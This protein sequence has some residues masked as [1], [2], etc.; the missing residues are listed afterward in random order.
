MSEQHLAGGTDAAARKYVAE[1]HK[2]LEPGR[3][4]NVLGHLALAL[5]CRLRRA[6]AATNHVDYVDADGGVHPAISAD[7]FIVLRA[8]N[9]S[10]LVQLRQAAAEAGVAC[11]DF[12][13]TMGEGG[14]AEQLRRTAATPAAALEY[15]GVALCGSEA[16]LGALTRKFSLYR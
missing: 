6:D 1:I 7:P 14:S 9:S 2:R 16:E 8:D 13:D 5:A 3:A 11:V 12:T 15:W 10:K 4:M